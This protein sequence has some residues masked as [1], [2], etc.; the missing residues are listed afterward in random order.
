MVDAVDA[1]RI[2]RG[3]LA[4]YRP[5]ADGGNVVRPAAE[6]DRVLG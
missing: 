5:K 3:L 4:M 1:E 2:A 6:H